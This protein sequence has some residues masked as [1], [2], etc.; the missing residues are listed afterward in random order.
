MIIE[1]KQTTELEI[2]FPSNFGFAE[3]DASL[4]FG[5]AEA[6][7]CFGE[8][9]VSLRFGEASLREADAEDEDEE[10]GSTKIEEQNV[11]SPT[12]PPERSSWNGNGST[13]SVLAPEERSVTLDWL[14]QANLDSPPG[15]KPAAAGEEEARGEECDASLKPIEGGDEKG[16]LDAA[17]VEDLESEVPSDRPKTAASA[18]DSVMDSSEA[19]HVAAASL[20]TV[21]SVL[22]P[23]EPTP[24]SST[25]LSSG[26]SKRWVDES[27]IGAAESRIENEEE[28]RRHESEG[29]WR[30]EWEGARTG[31]EEEDAEEGW[32]REGA[33]A[34]QEEWETVSNR[35]WSDTL[36][37]GWHDEDE[38]VAEEP[39][40]EPEVSSQQ[41]PVQRSREETIN[42]RARKL[43]LRCE[44]CGS[45]LYRKHVKENNK[46][47]FTCASHLEMS[48][49]EKIESLVDA[50]SW[51]PINDDI[52]PGDPLEFEDEKRYLNRLEESQ[53]RTGLQDAIQTGTAMVEGIPMAL[54]V[55]DFQ[56][57]GGS[58]GSVVGE[59]ITRLIEYAL[60]EG[61]FL[62]LVC[63]S[64]GARMQ[65]G[66][67]SLMQMAKISGALSIYRSCGN[68]VYLSLLTSPTTGG[69]TAS[70]AMLGEIIIAE[71]KAVIGFAGRRVIE[72][73]LQEELPPDF[74]TA[75]YLHHH[76]LVD[77]IV[78]RH[79]LREAFSECIAFHQTTL[80]KKGNLLRS[81]HF[82]TLSPSEDRPGVSL[83]GQKASHP[84]KSE[85]LEA[86]FETNQVGIDSPVNINRSQFFE[87][88]EIE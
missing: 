87:E 17:R 63:A 77:L 64:G 67:F 70:F 25:K 84:E 42:E 5:E 43:W 62:L 66:I 50:G 40:V 29:R 85:G 69:V 53:E 86:G 54:G 83:P 8:A 9:E 68:L 48:S 32:N 27:V 61:L 56:F 6:S 24:S 79:H 21:V 10:M 15:Q 39:D 80:L 11:I 19:F 38:M 22:L 4:R 51:K 88:I 12:S 3:A 45:I 46:V 65:E 31:Q 72:Q 49:E 2:P 1:E 33:E 71:P 60:E 16:D 57:M 13:R 23:P 74:Q 47:C 73:T 26:E 20:K 44:E 75:E 58:M 41:E 14:G 82:P 52:S 37:E 81:P 30:E 34:W 28:H 59:K 55:M 35:P 36:E 76:G 78:H 7:L 18:S